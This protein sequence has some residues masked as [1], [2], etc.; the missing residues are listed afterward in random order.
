MTGRTMTDS[1]RSLKVGRGPATGEAG[2]ATPTGTTVPKTEMAA[3]A[4]AAAMTVAAR[5]VTAGMTTGAETREEATE[6][7][8]L[9]NGQSC[10]KSFFTTRMSGAT[11]SRRG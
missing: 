3:P 9:K 8:A 6:Q 4:T 11:Q 2:A 10:H 1:A 7:T 5:T